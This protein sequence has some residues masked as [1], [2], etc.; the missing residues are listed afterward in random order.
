MKADI[1]DRRRA[2]VVE[3]EMPQF[4]IDKKNAFIE[5][6]RELDFDY[7]EI[8]K[9]GVAT[10]DINLVIEMVSERKNR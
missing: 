6:L 1:R 10:P 7:E 2:K 5:K 3:K 9:M 4:L 8:M